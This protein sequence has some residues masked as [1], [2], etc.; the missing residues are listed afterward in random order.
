MRRR[1]WDGHVQIVNRIIRV[2]VF[3]E[4]GLYAGGL[5][6]SSEARIRSADKG[7]GPASHC[8]PLASCPGDATAQ[9]VI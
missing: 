6:L 2:P 7:E 8:D 5:S 1:A 4:V 9:E 3:D